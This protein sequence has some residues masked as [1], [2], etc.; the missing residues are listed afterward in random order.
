[1]SNKPRYHDIVIVGAGI[2][3]T[4][5]AYALSRQPHLSI[6]LID[7]GSFDG[8]ADDP[9]AI[10][11]SFNSVTILQSLAIWKPELATAIKDIFVSDQGH[12]GATHISAIEEHLPALGYVINAGE[13]LQQLRHRL[14]QSNNIHLYPNCNAS[15]VQ[16][17]SDQVTISAS[18]ADGATTI[19]TRLLVL[20]EGSRGTI[21]DSLQCR[22][23]FHDYRQTA[24]VTTVTTHK[25]HN[26]R[27]Y[28]RFTRSGPIALL[29]Y[30]ADQN[31]EQQN[32]WS[33]VWTKPPAEAETLLQQPDEQFLAT[34]QQQFGKRAGHITSVGP[35]F[36]YPLQLRYR[37]PPQQPR[38]TLVGNAAHTIHPV[39]GQGLNLGLRDVAHLFDAITKGNMDFADAGSNNILNQYQAW[40]KFDQ[41]RV[42]AT[43]HLLATLFQP[44][45]PSL[46][47]LRGAALTTLDL[48]PSL[49]RGFTR[50]MLG[51][52]APYSR[53]GS[54]TLI[55]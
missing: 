15:A 27:A 18:N 53:L 30:S 54:S 40:R 52:I 2:V 3:G 10:A 37:H 21:V 46:G 19:H 23:Q 47:H 8:K 6:G 16:T 1:M 38:I 32:L 33:L 4:T 35:K 28:E 51:T 45:T 7:N 50:Q 13:L 24:I 39:A 22:E 25:P 11:L 29:P 48:V 14:Q 26:N 49:R 42:M 17:N 55:T 12:F 9:R 36:S 41:W 44:K 43:T 34:L 31:R 20:A 5:L